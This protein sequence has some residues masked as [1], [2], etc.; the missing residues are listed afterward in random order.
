MPSYKVYEDEEFVAFLDISPVNYGHALVIPKEHY[1][2][3]ENLPVEMFAKMMVVVKEIG[4]AVKRAL[5]VG[6]YNLILNND[7][8]AG[9]VIPHIHFHIIP[10]HQGD[11]LRAWPPGRYAEGDA[12]EIAEK[13]RVELE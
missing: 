8:V 5:G 1:T 3:L 13:I 7:A 2:N 10:R 4:A 11:N 12:P 9:Q 6:G